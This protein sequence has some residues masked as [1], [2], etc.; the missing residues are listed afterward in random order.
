V[1]DEQGI[2][3]VREGETGVDSLVAG[4]KVIV[5]GLQRVRPGM[6]VRTKPYELSPAA[7]IDR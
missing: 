3:R 6:E 1:R 4:E 2:R 7:L 5:S